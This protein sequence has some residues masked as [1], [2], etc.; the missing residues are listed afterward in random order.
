MTPEFKKARDEAAPYYSY[1]ARH[2]F[3]I[4][5]ADWAY[6]WLKSRY[7]FMAGMI[8]EMESE[9]DDMEHKLEALTR[10]AEALAKALERS[11]YMLNTVALET[12]HPERFKLR[13]QAGEVTRK[14]LARW[15]KFKENK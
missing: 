10:E 11:R 3:W 12:S 4:Q 8:K 6:E 2:E 15:K 7:N 9:T 5:G 13:E 1:S 14:A